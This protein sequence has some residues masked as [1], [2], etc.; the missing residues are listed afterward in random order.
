MGLGCLL[1]VVLYCSEWFWVCLCCS[2]LVYGCC[3]GGGG[4]FLVVCVAVL[5]VVGF[6]VFFG[7][8]C[9]LLFFCVVLVVF[10]ILLVGGLG[11][12]VFFFG[13][14]GCYLSVFLYRCFLFGSGLGL[15]LIYFFF[16][17]FVCAVI[18]M[19]QYKLHIELIEVANPA[20]LLSCGAASG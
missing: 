7:L 1:F 8:C 16:W 9:C 5:V 18:Y 20:P 13:W 11:V 2:A 19:G 6:V 3:C 10:C 17:C 12:G 15:F 4:F 14:I